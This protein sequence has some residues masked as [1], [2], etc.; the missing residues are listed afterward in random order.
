MKW[1]KE[2]I[3]NVEVDAAQI[4]D[5]ISQLVFSINDNNKLV[6]SCI[7]PH[8]VV[9]CQKD[10]IFHDALLNSDFNIP[11]GAGIVWASR[12]LGGNIRA[13]VTGSDIFHGLNDYLNKKGGTSCFFLGSSEDTLGKIRTRMA[14]EFPNVKIAGTYSPPFKEIFTEEENQDMLD[15][16]NRSDPDVLWVG[17]T[18]PKQ[19][20]WI[21]QNREKL[22]A[23]V[24]AAVGA[25]F[26]FY[27]GTKRRSTRFW[28]DKGLEWLPRFMREPRRLWR[29]NLVSS[30]MFIYLVLK[31]RVGRG[32]F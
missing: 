18:A 7:N 24:I 21:Y 22:N 19:E 17:M 3:L 29:R 12:F 31:E 28:Q 16:V 2:R 1:I 11:D 20:K 9:V 14:D 5:I 32:R 15:A 23:R 27:A 8:S 10:R 25:V 13:R 4:D 6:L 26:D 30:P